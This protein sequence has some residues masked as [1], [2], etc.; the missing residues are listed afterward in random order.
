MDYEFKYREL[1]EENKTLRKEKKELIKRKNHLEYKLLYYKEILI[2]EGLYDTQ[3]SKH[4]T[5]TT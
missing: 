2:R 1:L 4:K 3:R 5:K